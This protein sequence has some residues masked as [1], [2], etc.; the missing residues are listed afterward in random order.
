MISDAIQFAVEAH[1]GQQYSGQPYTYHL[2]RVAGLVQD[3]AEELTG[4]VSNEKM[5]AAGWLHD[6]LEDTTTTVQELRKRFGHDVTA[7]VVAVTDDPGE[8][9]AERHATTYPRIRQAGHQAVGLKLCDRLA[10][11]KGCVALNN[12]RLLRMYLSEH[13]GFR[14][15]LKRPDELPG[16]WNTIEQ[17]VSHYSK[18][19]GSF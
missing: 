17:V 4:A 6:V 1:A 11:L 19:A 5:I 9:R 13:L 18:V 3:Y 7:L 2:A 14:G 8:T 12:N 15:V 16:L 10:N